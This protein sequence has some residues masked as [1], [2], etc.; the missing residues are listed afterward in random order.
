MLLECSMGDCERLGHIECAQ[1][2]TTACVDHSD[3]CIHCGKAFC[4]TDLQAHY[5]P[6]DPECEVPDMEC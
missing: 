1:C 6:Q 4:N 3:L 2:G 5:C